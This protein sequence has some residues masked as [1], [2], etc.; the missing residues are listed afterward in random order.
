[1][2]QWICRQHCF[3]SPHLYNQIISS[4]ASFRN[5]I[6][7]YVRNRIKQVPQVFINFFISHSRPF[8]L[9]LAE[10]TSV[11]SFSASAIC[12]SFISA[13]ICFDDCL[14]K[15]SVLSK[16]TCVFFLQLFV[17]KTALMTSFAF[18]KCFFPVL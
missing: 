17:S 16:S 4:R 15:E 6:I 2:W 14:I 11:L 5:F 3:C 8:A 12:P 13:P 18:E 10:A 9:S 1:M 7:R